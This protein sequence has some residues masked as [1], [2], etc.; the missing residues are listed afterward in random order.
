MSHAP[1]SPTAEHLE[2][3]RRLKALFQAMAL[4]DPEGTKAA[5]AEVDAMRADLETTTVKPRTARQIAKDEHE[6]YWAG[7]KARAESNMRNGRCL[8]A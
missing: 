2:G 4:A 5:I 6:A 8:E 7:V 3:G 1:T